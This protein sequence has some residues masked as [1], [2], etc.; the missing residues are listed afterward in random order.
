MKCQNF[1]DLNREIVMRII[2]ADSSSLA[3]TEARFSKEIY[4]S[5]DNNIELMLQSLCSI[6]IMRVDRK[7][8]RWSE[9][10]LKRVEE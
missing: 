7:L 9:N 5:Y 4:T 2:G 1:L 8:M 3:Q 10:K 6:V